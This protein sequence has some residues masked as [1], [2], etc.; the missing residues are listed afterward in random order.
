M[1]D[2]YCIQIHTKLHGLWR[3]VAAAGRRLLE[4]QGMAGYGQLSLG[5]AA[6]LLSG[7][8][9]S[10]VTLATAALQSFRVRIVSS[11]NVS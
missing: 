5:R 9:G 6:D 10:A 3:Q 7:Q 1:I 4:E 8:Q 11:F 2:F